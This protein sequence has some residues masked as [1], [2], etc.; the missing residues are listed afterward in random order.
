[1]KKILSFF[2][3]ILLLGCESLRNNDNEIGI[4][5]CPEVFFSSENNVFAQGD[6]ESLNLDK[7][8]YKA[9]L[10]NYG[11]VNNCFVDKKNNNYLLDLLILVDPINPKD[12]NINLPIFVLIY[13]EK[14]RI[15]DKHYF[16]IFDSL[17]Y[18]ENISDY[19][20]TEVKVNLKIVI[21]KNKE[22]NFFTVGFV[23]LK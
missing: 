2:V 15:I 13:D 7:I 8:Q 23:K 12:Q 19:Q 9:A 21:D 22:A 18:N 17:S 6:I 11:F 20:L 14:D 3:F 5:N 10:N 1:M 4:I 16:R